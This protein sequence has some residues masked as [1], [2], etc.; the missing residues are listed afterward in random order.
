MSARGFVAVLCVLC[1]LGGAVPGRCESSLATGIQQVQEGENQ[2][3][4]VTLR[5]VAERLS[6]NPQ[7]R[8]DLKTAYVYMA[9][10]HLGLSQE[11]EAQR[12]FLSALKIDSGLV[13]RT[14]DFPP[15]VVRFFER[16]RQEAIAAG[17]IHPPRAKS[18]GG[19]KWIL[20]GGGLAAAG[21]G[22]AVAL[23]GAKNKPPTVGDIVVSPRVVG[24]ANLT[25]FEFSAS[26]S[27]P[28]GDALTYQWTFGDGNTSTLA[29]PK[30][31]Y[32]GTSVSTPFQVTLTVSDGV[33]SSDLKSTSVSVTLL[34]GS[35]ATEPDANHII[36]SLLLTQSGTLLSG[37]YNHGGCTTGGSANGQV[38]APRT[39]SLQ[40]NAGCWE[41]ITFSGTIS[42]DAKSM[43]GTAQDTALTFRRP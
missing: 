23:G 4:V 18:G 22:A 15:R 16:V 29:A 11:P 26:A 5:A 21:A 41:P 20:I 39:V 19:T 10:A 3:A 1:L 32:S 6:S 2:P 37:A 35:W 28:N 43:S 42:D 36:R 25:E 9:V 8:A 33:S 31:V 27:D 14:S 40:L 12:A 34:D 13:V 7:A 17:V 24:I 38:T 30:H